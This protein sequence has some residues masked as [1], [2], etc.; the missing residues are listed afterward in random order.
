MAMLSRDSAIEAKST[1]LQSVACAMES[2]SSCLD[3]GATVSFLTSGTFTLARSKNPSSEAE[4]ATELAKD[5][6]SVESMEEKEDKGFRAEAASQPSS[7][8]PSKI[9]A[10]RDADL[11][12]L[13]FGDD[14]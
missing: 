2:K 5:V 8:S 12:L 6:Q 3:L 4:L 13:V 14:R 11:D 10:K 7:S 1:Q 9:I